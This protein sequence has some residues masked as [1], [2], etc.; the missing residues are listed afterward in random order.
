MPGMSCCIRKAVGGCFTFVDDEALVGVALVRFLVS[1]EGR[2]YFAEV[3]YW[4]ECAHLN[5]MEA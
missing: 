3:A 1:V 5:V 4:D 2:A